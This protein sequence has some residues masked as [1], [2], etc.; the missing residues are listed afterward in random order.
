MGKLNTSITS[1]H[2]A[3]TLYNRYK[4]EIMYK[5]DPVGAR[6]ILEF[7][8]LLIH[9]SHPSLPGYIEKED[10]PCGVKLMDWPAKTL[11]EVGSFFSSRI[12]LGDMR[13]YLPRECEIEGLFT[14]GSVGSL[15]QTRESDY[16]IWVVVDARKMDPSRLKTLDLKL[17][18]LKRWISSKF[19]LD[20]HFF[21]MD[22]QDIRANNFG[23]VSQEGSG[24]ALKSILK[25]EFYRT[26]TLI[27]GRVPLW[28]IVAPEE[29]PEGYDQVRRMVQAGSDGETQKFID[30]GNISAIPEQ[31]L[32][33]AA[34][35]QMHKA[36]D[37]PLKS[38]LKMALVASYLDTPKKDSLL[39]NML[40]KDVFD[41]SRGEIVDP[42][43]HVLRRVE[44]YYGSRGDDQTVELLR[45]CFY[46]KVNPNIRGTD[47]IKIEKDD[48]PSIM[49]D[50][51]KAWG[52]SL[53]TFS[54]LNGFTEWG[55]DM[56]RK[57]GD[58]IHS[59]LKLT[60]VQLIRRAKT[61]MINSALEEDV[62]VEVLRRRIEAFYVS[63][64][65]KVESEKRVKKKEP[66]YRDLYFAYRRNR[67]S[68][69]ERT[70]GPN[71]GEP[72]MESDRVVRILAWLVYNKRFD[73]STAFH[74]IPNTS[75]VVLSDIQS[76]LLKLGGVIPDAGSIGLDRSSLME[77]KYARFV[78]VVGNMECPDS[79][80][81]IREVDVLFLNTWNEFFCIHLRP[82]QIGPWMARMKRNS[83]EVTIWLPKEGNTKFLTQA[84]VSLIS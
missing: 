15:A 33:G 23:S 65:G 75:R 59:F 47:L 39:C 6:V 50:I 3:F 63:K 28:W 60:T 19:A 49:V 7:L 56:Y 84:L 10:C 34:L 57:F 54:E 79:Q 61:Y 41:T 29:G 71:G 48:K 83:T 46:L 30:M 62:E 78:V 24:T 80:H 36:L 18:L 2:K 74:M 43:F 72:I 32:L 66:A 81:S 73:A 42:Y 1:G 76:L 16:D 64:D 40:K 26:M 14:I 11:K 13:D 12:K 9:I 5:C 31:E 38:V 20:I 58:D 17:K 69:H 22:L 52:W 37:D 53:H 70:P 8:P 21:L 27:E 35:W 25:E 82:E 68:I 55:V 51:V 44:D 67:W 45:K 4:K 77:D